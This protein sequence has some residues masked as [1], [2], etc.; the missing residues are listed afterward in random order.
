MSLSRARAACVGALPIASGL[1]GHSSAVEVGHDGDLGKHALR[2]LASDG[3]WS[4]ELPVDKT[5]RFTGAG[6]ETIEKRN[7]DDGFDKSHALGS[8][9]LYKKTSKKLLRRAAKF[10]EDEERDKCQEKSS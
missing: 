10:A 5:S 3:T 6:A 7:P 8:Q 1:Q 4:A 9:R 2:T